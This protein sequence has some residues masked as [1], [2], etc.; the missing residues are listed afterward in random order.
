MSVLSPLIRAL[1]MDDNFHCAESKL[2]AL[3]NVVLCGQAVKSMKDDLQKAECVA[4]HFDTTTL[5]N[6]KVLVILAKYFLP[7]EGVQVRCLDV[8]AIVDEKA[9]DMTRYLLDAIVNAG[10]DPSKVKIIA[11][12]NTNMNFGGVFHNGDNNVATHLEAALNHGLFRSGC[13][14][15]IA[16]NTFSHA[17]NQVK[18]S[19]LFNLPHVLHQPYYYFHQKVTARDSF[20][21]FCAERHP[22]TRIAPLRSF[23]LTR[24]TSALSSLT[25]LDLN[26][27]VLKPFFK[28]QFD[29]L[30]AAKRAN[31]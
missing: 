22:N 2:A 4:I 19:G 27:P 28:K 16:N 21:A 12:D 29:D 3:I 20:I 17:C 30:P 11:A 31:K 14:L 18:E 5:H 8:R 10:L 1:G 25:N 23:G 26:Y 9:T 6:T 13:L 7:L 24:W 15:H